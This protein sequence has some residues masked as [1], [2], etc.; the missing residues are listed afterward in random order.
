MIY[1]SP[2]FPLNFRINVL[3]WGEVEWR[4]FKQICI[5]NSKFKGNG[6]CGKWSFD[7]DG[8][9]KFPKQCTNDC[10]EYLKLE[11]RRILEGG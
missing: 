1:D 10:R 5:K 2:S 4:I 9:P 11:V 6:G 3:E 8:K 7:K